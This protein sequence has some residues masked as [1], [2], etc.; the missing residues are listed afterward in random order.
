[1]PVAAGY[2]PRPIRDQRENGAATAMMNALAVFEKLNTD[3]RDYLDA[4]SEFVDT[5]DKA[6]TKAQRAPAKP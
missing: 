3:Q 4:L 5:Y 2:L 1:M 6:R